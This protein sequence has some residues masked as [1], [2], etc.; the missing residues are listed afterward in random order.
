LRKKRLTTR[1]IYQDLWQKI[2]NF[3]LFPGSRVTENEL[4]D[5]YKTSRTPIR[6]AL[7]RLEVEGLVTVRPKQGCFVRQV[8]IALISDYY[9]IRVALEA[10]TVE[11]AIQNMSDDELQ[12]LAE[13]WNPQQFKNNRDDLESIKQFEESFHLSIAKG[14]RNP[15]LVQ[16]LEDV[17][18]HIRPIRMLGFPDTKSVKDTYDEHFEIISLIQQR[19][20]AKAKE[21]MIA[22][23]RKSQNTARSVTLTQLEQYRK[24]RP[25]RAKSA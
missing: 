25:R 3:D 4:A 14:S 6:E 20:V 22:H 16:Y 11:L 2:I 10:M 9:T 24:K 21:A 5:E 12:T 17:N 1:E 15:V 19:D 8:D 23:I 18:N 7:K 13:S